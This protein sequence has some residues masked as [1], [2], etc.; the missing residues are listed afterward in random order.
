M[1]GFR[2]IMFN[3]IE[4]IIED[5]KVGKMVVVADDESRENE[6]DLIFAAQF[7]TPEKVNF[8]MRHA[9]GLI[10]VPLTDERLGTLGLWNMV[11]GMEDS[12]KTA[13]TVSVDAALAVTTGISAHDRARTIEV[14]ADPKS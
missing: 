10:C 14:L 8:M 6:G 7:V 1:I 9:R 3:S 13:F 12:M 4:E 11:T 5:I 2:A